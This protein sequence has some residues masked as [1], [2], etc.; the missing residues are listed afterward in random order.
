MESS[1]CSS[2]CSS[3]RDWMNSFASPGSMPAASQSITISH[4]FSL[5]TSESS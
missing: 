1:R 3:T 4:T 2:A 5:M